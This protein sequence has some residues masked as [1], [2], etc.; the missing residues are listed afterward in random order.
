MHI[1]THILSGWCAGNLI[2]RL[3][4]RQ[5]LM[6]MIA[7]SIADLDGLSYLGGQESFW[8]WHH[9][10]CHN[11]AFGVISSAVMTWVSGRKFWLFVLYLGLFHLHLNMDVFGSGPGWGIYYFWP[12]SNWM[13]DNTS[14]SWQFFSWQNITAAAAL[15]V[16]TVGIAVVNGRTPLE[17]IMPNLDRQL[18]QIARN[19]FPIKRQPA[20]TSD[21]PRT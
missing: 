11:L 16:W 10:V 8:R 12:F 19:I 4:G 13:F 18:V 1:P 14:Y 20:V 7:A 15:F 21:Q 17:A 6:C 3:N 5:R 9:K 2:S